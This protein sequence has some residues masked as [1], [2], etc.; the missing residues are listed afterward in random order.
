MSVGHEKQ[1]NAPAAC[2]KF[3]RTPS[4]AWWELETPI[5]S[6]GENLAC[7]GEI[8][9]F[10]KQP[11][12]EPGPK[13]AVTRSLAQKIPSVQS[14]I[15]YLRRDPAAPFHTGTGPRK[16]YFQF[17]LLIS[18]WKY[19]ICSYFPT[20]REFC[21]G[22]SVYPLIVTLIFFSKN[23]GSGS[24]VAAPNTPGQVQSHPS[25]MSQD[26]NVNSTSLLHCQ[27]CFWWT[28]SK[29]E[30]LLRNTI[31]SKGRLDLDM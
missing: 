26:G 11:A 27:T 16:D 8:K 2:Y 22:E 5:K 23:S 30:H 13:S 18:L 3:E 14:K 15:H 31:S 25:Q 10:Q 20:E 21:C 1:I 4:A 28:T 24:G 29:I 12:A 7:S 19:E 6:Y 17:S 9:L